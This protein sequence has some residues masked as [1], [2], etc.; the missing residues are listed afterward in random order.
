MNNRHSRFSGEPV[1]S[2]YAMTERNDKNVE[3]TAINELT[4]KIFNRTP[5]GLIFSEDLKRIYSILLICLDLCE[6]PKAGQNKLLPNFIKSYPFSFHVREAITKMEHLPLNV[7]IGSASINISYSIRPELAY[8]LLE[9]FMDAKLLHA[10]ADRTRSEPKEKVLLQPTPKGVAILQRYVRQ[11]GL[12]DWPPILTSDFN[13]MELFVF[14]RSSMTDAIIQSSYFISVLFTKMMGPSPNIWTPTNPPDSLPSLNKLL[15]CHEDYFSF[16]N[17]NNHW[18]SKL[19]IPQTA[20]ANHTGSIRYTQQSEKLQNESRLSPF[21]HRFFTNPDSTAHIQY[22]VSDCGIRVFKS[23]LFG[24]RKLLV[25]YTFTTKAIWQWLMDCTDIFYPKEAVILAS[26]FLKNGLMTQVPSRSSKNNKFFISSNSFYT[27]TE[28]GWNIIQWNTEL[29]IKACIQ[30]IDGKVERQIPK[31]IETFRDSRVYGRSFESEHAMHV[32]NS[33]MPLDLIQVLKDPGMR[34]LFRIHLEKEFCA[35]N[36]DAYIE[37]KKFSKKMTVL[38]NLIETRA[39]GKEDH[40][41]S[42]KS[43]HFS[44][45]LISTVNIALINHANECLEMAYRIFSSYIAIGSSFQLNIDYSLRECITEVVLRPRSILDVPNVHAFASCNSLQLNSCSQSG[46]STIV[47]PEQSPREIISQPGR[48]KCNTSLFN[49]KFISIGDNDVSRTAGKRSLDILH[50]NSSSNVQKLPDTLR[51]LKELY[52]L[53]ERVSKRLYRLMKVD[54]F[55]KFIN[56]K[57]THGAFS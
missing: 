7:T 30:T 32:F 36:L 21:A 41:T 12:K 6:N 8:K 19:N 34:Y 46:L 9:I 50:E 51:I 22:Y 54:S 57:L 49:S 38:R 29:G 14:E 2:K 27:L 23:R 33:P 52:P 24:D 25:D 35:E 56:S 10:P 5:S 39:L 11:A 13:S 20:P 3:G 45:L 16:E 40:Q 17:L 55:P 26:Y 4:S 48:K 53:F 15:E 42:Q 44:S 43:K 18:D 31:M 47:L 28:L 1:P 37:I